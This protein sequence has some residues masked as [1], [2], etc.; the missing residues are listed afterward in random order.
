M[1]NPKQMTLWTAVVTPFNED[2]SVDWY[3]FENL[4]RKQEQ[5][6]NG[7]VLLA[8]TGEGSAFSDEEKRVVMKRVAALNLSVPIMVGV[9]GFNLPSTI[10]WLKFCEGLPID[11]YLLVTPP[12]SKPGPRGQTAWFKALL[13]AVS[14]PC[15]LYNVPSRTGCQL[16]VD[17]VAALSTHPNCWAIKEASGSVSQFHN[18]R[19]AAPGVLL[20]SGDDGLMPTLAA[21]GAKGLVSVIAN[22]WPKGTR[23]YVSQCAQNPNEEVIILWRRASEAM[24][25]TSNP[26][27]IKRLLYTKGWIKTPLVRPPLSSDDLACDEELRR[28]DQLVTEWLSPKAALSAIE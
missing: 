13:D 26:V 11:A 23:K 4:L 14:K 20:Y 28:C 16:S 5:A 22:A 7:V 2:L 18:Y 10:S 17:A 1:K 25:T 6:G 19:N 8:S 21:E 15:M 3:S 12:Y 24:F 9:G 27:P